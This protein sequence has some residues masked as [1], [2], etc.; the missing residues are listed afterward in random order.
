MNTSEIRKEN[1]I[2]LYNEKGEKHGYWERYYGNGRL[3]Y[4]GNYVDGREHGYWE[5]YFD[6]GR[7]DYKGNYLN[8][9]K[10]GYWEDYYD[11][12]QLA[13]KGNY[14]NGEPH[15]YWEVYYENGK[16]IYKG[17]YDMGK[18]VDYNPDE[19]KIV[20]LTLSDIANKL[21]VDVDKLRIKE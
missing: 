2:N 10:H 11:N 12:G 18:R 14:V 3:W 19:P 21:G 17:Y 8:G 4:K 1:L 6:N 7:L 15:G 16:L 5:V 9:K 20:E 13:Y